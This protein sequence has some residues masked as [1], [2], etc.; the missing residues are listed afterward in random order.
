MRIYPICDMSVHMTRSTVRS[1]RRPMRTQYGV[2]SRP[3]ILPAPPS[4]RLSPQCVT[5]LSPGSPSLWQSQQC[6]CQYH[7]AQLLPPFWPFLQKSAKI[8]EFFYGTGHGF[9]SISVRLL[10]PRMSGAGRPRS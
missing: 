6:V 7:T 10:I 2:R 1:A 8:P 3:T 4:V 5:A 9:V